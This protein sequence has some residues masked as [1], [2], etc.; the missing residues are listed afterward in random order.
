M[1]ELGSARAS[2]ACQPARPHHHSLQVVFTLVLTSDSVCVV[3]SH[4]LAARH[5]QSI[6][7]A[8]RSCDAG[9]DVMGN[10]GL[11]EIA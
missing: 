1:P 8:L 9:Q 11:Q 5:D 6:S 10:G 4:N 2:Q 3:T 7:R